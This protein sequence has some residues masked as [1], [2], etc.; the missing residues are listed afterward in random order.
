MGSACPEMGGL[1]APKW[2]PSAPTSPGI[3]V[4]RRPKNFVVGDHVPDGRRFR[5]A[6]T[7]SPHLY[8]AGVH[9][10]GPPACPASPWPCAQPLR[11]LGLRL[12]IGTRGTEPPAFRATRV[13][14]AVP[15]S[16]P[17]V[18]CVPRRRVGEAVETVGLRRLRPLGM[19]QGRPVAA[20]VLRETRWKATPPAL[21]I[22]MAQVPPRGGMDRTTAPP[23][24]HPASP[25]L[26]VPALALCPMDRAVRMLAVLVAFCAHPRIGSVFIELRGGISVRARS[27]KGAHLKKR[28]SRRRRR[29]GW[30]GFPG[31]PCPWS[32]PAR[33]KE[34][35]PPRLSDPCL[36]TIPRER[37]VPKFSYGLRP[38]A[39][40][41]WM[42][43]LSLMRA[44]HAR[45]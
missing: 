4:G 30:S 31:L 42:S 13:E 9:R 5:A 20:N 26:V 22:H 34:E 25:H 7:R 38:H 21:P 35:K 17:A 12:S 18:R 2:V 16:R 15:M 29:P 28:G 11:R 24:E 23:T 10:N 32:H 6:A 37:V 27:H 40:S 1:H 36:A 14:A 8:V 33:P 41:R 45:Q 44:S 39:R 43:A 19:G 3:S